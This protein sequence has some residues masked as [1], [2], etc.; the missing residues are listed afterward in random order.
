MMLGE[1]EA[2][3][4]DTKGTAHSASLS[5]VIQQA[6]VMVVVHQKL[7]EEGANGALNRPTPSAHSYVQIAGQKSSCR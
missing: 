5:H 1:V 6:L 3:N 4:N 2:E 7:V